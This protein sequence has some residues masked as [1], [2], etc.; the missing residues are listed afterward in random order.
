MRTLGEYSRLVSEIEQGRYP[1]GLDSK[2]AIDKL[3]VEICVVPWKTPEESA[4]AQSLALRL[5]IVYN[6][7]EGEGNG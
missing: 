5:S 3:I 1:P 4:Q 7:S 2:E 6:R